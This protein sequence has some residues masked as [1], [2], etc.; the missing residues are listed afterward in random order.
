MYLSG[1]RTLGLI[2]LRWILDKQRSERVETLLERVSKAD[3]LKRRRHMDF[4]NNK[5]EK[6]GSL[7]TVISNDK[8]V[9]MNRIGDV[10]TFTV[11][12]RNTGKVSSE[13]FFSDLPF[14]SNT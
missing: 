7:T 12:D 2:P 5:G 8:S 13:T 9:T 1:E 11:R 4:I 3:D 10:T 14:G 6:I